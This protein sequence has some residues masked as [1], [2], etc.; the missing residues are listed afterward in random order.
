MFQSG[1]V[2]SDWRSGMDR[3]RQHNQGTGTL[4]ASAGSPA[5]STQGKRTLVDAIAGGFG[6]G[7]PAHARPAAPLVAERELNAVLKVV[8]LD[9]HGGVIRTWGAKATWEGPLPQHF[10]GDHRSGT[11]HWDDA[12][13]VRSVRVHTEAN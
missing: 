13:S 8:A 9:A 5:D 12:A 6:V 1:I 4:I 11:W 10:H 7:A 2:T 3:Q